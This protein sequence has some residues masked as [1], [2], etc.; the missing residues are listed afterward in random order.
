MSWMTNEKGE[1]YTTIPKDYSDGRTKQSFKDDTDVNLIIQKHT[2]MGTI[3]HLE[4]WGGNYG[5]YSD[6]NFQDAQNQI[7]NANSMFEQLPAG[8]R[9][10]FANSPEQFFKYVN[11]PQ[12]KDNLA[13]LLPELAA[14][15]NKAMPKPAEIEEPTPPTPPTPG[16]A[17]PTEPE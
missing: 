15:G 2:R 5:D 6:F 10:Q 8:L 14:P 12:N 16:G 4:Q 1:H 11:D 7:A 9:N 17:E 3:S 13:Q